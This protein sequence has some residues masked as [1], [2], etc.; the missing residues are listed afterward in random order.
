M[1]RLED[2]LAGATQ[3]LVGLVVLTVAF[4]ASHIQPWNVPGARA[5]RWVVLAELA[6]FAV[7]LLVVRRSPRVAG[8]AVLAPAAALALLAAAST[9]WSADPRLT[10]GRALAFVVLLVT[11]AAVATATR[12]RPGLAGAVLLA[13]VA[14]AAVIAIAGLVELLHAR[15]QAIVPATRGQG[16]R[17][18]GIGQNPNQIAMLLALVLPLTLWLVREAASPARRLTAAALL[19][20]FAGSIVASGSRGATFA[21][22]AGCLAY[23]ML[24]FR[25]RRVRGVLGVA[26]ATVLAA[27]ALQLP[28][29]AD[30]DPVLNEDFGVT[31]VL[32]EYDVNAKLP[33]ESE[34]GFPAPDAPEAR[35]TLIF[36]SGRVEAWGQAVDQALERPLVGFGFGT[37]DRVFVDRSYLFVSD[38]VENS[39]VGMLLELGP[40]GVLLLAG[41]LAVPL[42]AWWRTH[43]RG[44]LAG[45]RADVA[46]A[47]V[48]VV[49]GGVVLAVPQSYVTSVGSPPTAP[50]W[51]CVFLLAGLTSTRR[52]HGHGERRQ[53]EVEAA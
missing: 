24:A 53:G 33:L 47:C 10:L 9:A 11:F 29:E 28:P 30:V 17:Y 39:F 44:G 51:L 23:V 38:R 20:L 45:E 26:A 41:S 16:A 15:D 34:Y 7:A 49:A 35:R 12:E 5:L 42:A 13:V 2:Q 43:R 21:A 8:L 4:A 1:R 36:S 6:A 22:S 37:E 14:A 32:S 31:P 50:L 27:L 52:E 40:L 3:L 48:A 19:A 46:A 18:N 25:R